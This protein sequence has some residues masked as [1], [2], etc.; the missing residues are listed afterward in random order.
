M[1]L[2]AADHRSG[3]ADYHHPIRGAAQ[4]M[5]RQETVSYT[6]KINHKIITSSITL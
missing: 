2:L 3:G 1:A 5:K 4:E 6:S